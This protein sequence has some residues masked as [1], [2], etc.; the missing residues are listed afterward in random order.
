MLEN[1]VL[2]Q[3]HEKIY[4]C[5]SNHVYL[6][7]MGPYCTIHTVIEVHKIELQIRAYS[8]YGGISPLW[9]YTYSLTN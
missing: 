5:P 2:V 8:L 7:L 6:S 9:S 4:Y 1:W 3:K